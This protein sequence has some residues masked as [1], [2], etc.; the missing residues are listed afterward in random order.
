MNCPRCKNIIEDDE[1]FCGKCGWS[2]NSIFYKIKTFFASQYK[3][4]LLVIGILCSLFAIILI[5]IFAYRFINDYFDNSEFKNNIMSVKMVTEYESDTLISDVDSIIFG[6]YIQKSEKRDD[7][8]EE[9]ENRVVYE[10]E[11]EKANKENKKSS[12]TNEEIEKDKIEWIVLEKDE[13]NHRV[14]LLS[15]YL[16]DS[17]CYNE[18]TE[19]VSWENSDIRKWLNEDFYN[20]AFDEKEKERII[21]TELNNE[22]SLDKTVRY[23]EY[24]NKDS[25]TKDKV[26]LLS[27]E[28]VAKYF[29]SRN[30]N[31]YGFIA[32]RIAATK[33]T[34]YARYAK[35]TY[36][37]SGKNQPK[38]TPFGEGESGINQ[39]SNLWA[40]GNNMYWLRIPM[41]VNNTS[42]STV[43]AYSRV[44]YGSL[45]SSFALGVRP[46]IW[47]SY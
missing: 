47:I 33:Q 2:R 30:E 44:F 35:R 24:L 21:E 27:A 28:E 3:K 26:F 32:G 7:E 17:Y 12:D 40:K 45:H 34:D 1:L 39:S 25:K 5:G 43:S 15:K 36:P 18:S 9:N 6:S 31:Q 13:E 11:I 10:D 20:A 46:A 4:I 16:L 29:S 38:M 14:L 23:A 42:P 41:D 19:N 37:K 8:D 22:Y